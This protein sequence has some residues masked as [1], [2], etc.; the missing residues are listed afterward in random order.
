MA[1]DT[2]YIGLRRISYR[3][4]NRVVRR[5]WSALRCVVRSPKGECRRTGR[6]LAFSQGVTQGYEIG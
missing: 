2:F 3:R 5:N 6:R 1:A 4:G